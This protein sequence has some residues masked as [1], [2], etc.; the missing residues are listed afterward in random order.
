LG[1][2]L[3]QYKTAG[4]YT[5]KNQEGKY[6]STTGALINRSASHNITFLAS[7]PYAGICSA[8]GTK[9]WQ[10]S[11]TQVLQVGPETELTDFAFE[12]VPAEEYTGIRSIKKDVTQKERN[13]YDINGRKTRDVRK[14]GIY[15]VNGEKRVY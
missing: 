5:V 9:Y 1:V 10:L 13:I 12:L 15:I 11:E 8:T 4:K 2:N 6:V 7:T 3:F 14:G